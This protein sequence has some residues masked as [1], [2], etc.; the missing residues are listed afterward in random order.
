[1]PTPTQREP[2]RNL[3][4][5]REYLHTFTQRYLYLK[6]VADYFGIRHKHN[7]ERG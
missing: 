2:Q 3:V 7:K 6:K 5:R 4:A 1:M